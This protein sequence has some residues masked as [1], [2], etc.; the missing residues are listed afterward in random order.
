[1]GLVS[2]NKSMPNSISHSGGTLGRSLRNTY[3]NCLTTGTDS[4]E[5]VSYSRSLTLTTLY[6]QT[7]AIILQAFKQEI[8]LPLGIEFPP[9]HSKM[10]SL[11]N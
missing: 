3:G 5:G 2:G 6:R 10:G 11:G 8:I 1:M 7:L 9:F 4:I